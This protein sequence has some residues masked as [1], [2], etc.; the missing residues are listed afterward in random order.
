M[1]KTQSFTEVKDRSNTKFLAKVFGYMFIGLLITA[2]V[3][4]GWSLAIA[5]FLVDSNGY[6]TDT[7]LT[8]IIATAIIGGIGGIIVPIINGIISIKTGKAPWIGYIIYAIC[9]GL[10]FSLVMLGGIDLGVVAEA[11]AITALA[12]GSMF[13]VGFFSK[14]NL[15]WLG[16]IAMGLSVSVL[17]TS[18]FWGLFYLFAPSAAII[19]DYLVSLAVIAIAMIFVAIDTYNIKQISEKGENNNNVALYCAFTMY[20]D[21][22]MLFVKI[23]YLLSSSKRNN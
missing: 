20:A 18:L 4:F 14:K 21:F 3:S 6:I 12:F 1:E 11:F 2:A 23:L 15:N 13:L 10:L 5:Y 17:L 8:A 19:L 22:I 7:G 16:M 9:I